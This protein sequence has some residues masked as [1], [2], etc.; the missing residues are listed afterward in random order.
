MSQP[1]SIY[2]EQ[3]GQYQQY[4]QSQQSTVGFQ[5]EVPAG[6]HSQQGIHGVQSSIQGV[7]GVQDVQSEH[8]NIQYSGIKGN[9]GLF[10]SIQSGIQSKYHFTYQG[11]SQQHQGL[12]VGYTGSG[13]YHAGGFQGILGQGQKTQDANVNKYYQNKHISEIIGGAISLD[14]KPLGYPLDRP[15]TTNALSVPNVYVQTVYISH[16]GQPTNEVN[17]H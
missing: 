1:Q 3:Q 5:G 16:E 13:Q 11:Q 4:Q 14:G 8:G 2:Q 15:L 10:N 12:S 9:Q 7:H 6:V 17:N